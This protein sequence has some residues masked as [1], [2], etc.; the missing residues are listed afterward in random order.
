MRKIVV[1]SLITVLIFSIIVFFS[2]FTLFDNP[3]SL[4]M[5][6]SNPMK[7]YYVE[8]Y[9]LHSNATIQGGIQVKKASKTEDVVLK[10]YLIYDVI[11]YCELKQ[12]TLY[13]KLSDSQNR[14]AV[15]I[16]TMIIDTNK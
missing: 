13:L 2:T 7:N 15:V 10:N 8:V 5:Q 12:D 11:D 9:K 6:I 16:D 4:S 1:F 14:L 3:K